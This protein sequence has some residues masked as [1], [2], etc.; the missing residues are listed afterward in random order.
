MRGFGIKETETAT[1]FFYCPFLLTYWTLAINILNN[2]GTHNII[3]AHEIKV[4]PSKE[5]KTYL[6]VSRWTLFFHCV[7]Q[8]L[9]VCVFL[10]C[11]VVTHDHASITHRGKHWQMSIFKKMNHMWGLSSCITRL[12]SWVMWHIWHAMTTVSPTNTHTYFCVI[13][14]MLCKS[15]CRSVVLWPRRVLMPPN[16]TKC[17]SFIVDVWLENE[18][19]VK[20][21]GL[22]YRGETDIREQ[23]DS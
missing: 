11:S 19:A 5:E 8:T 12:C 22:S 17:F 2:R 1:N 6:H 16:L 3:Q 9:W 15:V 14:R 10:R 21:Y 18:D 4:S 7:V 23:I 20:L 13:T